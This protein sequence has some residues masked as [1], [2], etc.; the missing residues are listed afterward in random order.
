M[1]R[2]AIPED[3]QTRILLRSRRRCC[4]CFWLKGEDEVKKGQLAHLDGDHS[5]STEG[6]L[7]F[8]CLEHHDEYDST[9]SVSKGL[10][11]REV[12]QWRDE[13]Y[14][15]MEYRFR[16]SRRYAVDLK[17]LRIVRTHAGEDHSN[18][19]VHFRLHNLGE[20]EIHSPTVSIALT[21]AV[22]PL[23]EPSWDPQVEMALPSM[24]ACSSELFERNG[25]IAVI[26]PTAVLMRDH[27]VDFFGLS[28]F[29]GSRQDGSTCEI[30]YRV[31]GLGMTPL[32]GRL[33]LSLPSDKA[34]LVSMGLLVAEQLAKPLRWP[35]ST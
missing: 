30:H 4:L 16:G 3:V 32:P 5:N 15:E 13:I 1:T 35:L 23:G 11:E 20:A 17:V 6:N 24:R 26:T 12:L 8:L 19:S 9:P 14:R 28:W 29:V 31:D 10:R 22:P 18:Y 25:R 2:K 33:T 21:S 27:S 34:M 7:A